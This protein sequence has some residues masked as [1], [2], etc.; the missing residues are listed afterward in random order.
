MRQAI[1]KINPRIYIEE[2]FT[3]AAHGISKTRTVAA[4][5]QIFTPGDSACNTYELSP[6]EV[7]PCQCQWDPTKKRVKA[8]FVQF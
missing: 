6:G 8:N 2:A 1:R 3:I 5:I 4:L 7:D